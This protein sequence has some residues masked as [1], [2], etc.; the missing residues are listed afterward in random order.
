MTNNFVR[1]HARLRPRQA[2]AIGVATL[3]FVGVSGSGAPAAETS[4]AA[5]G[6]F[7]V[8]IVSSG[9]AINI[10]DPN[11]V[12]Q[13]DVSV[14]PYTALANLDNLGQSTAQAG[15]PFLGDYVGPLVGHYNGLAA[16]Q[17]PP[18]PPIP[19]EVRSSYPGQPSAAQR[20]GGYS[21]EATSAENESTGAVNLGSAAPGSQ[22]AQLYSLAHAV[23]GAKG[24]LQAVGSAGADLLN[25]AGVLNIGRVSS[26]ITMTQS[27]SGAPK[28]VTT[29]DV[30]TISVSGQKFG[31]DQNGLTFAGT[32]SGASAAQVNDATQALKDSGLSIRLIP[33]SV[34][35]APGTQTVESLRSG[36][37]EVSYAQEV[38]SQGLVTNTYTLGFVE[39]SSTSSSYGT[40]AASQFDNVSADRRASSGKGSATPRASQA[41][42]LTSAGHAL[43]FSTT[44]LGAASRAPAHKGEAAGE[45]KSVALITPTLR[46]LRF[47]ST[48]GLPDGCNIF[49]G[50]LGAGAGE[51]GGG[52]DAGTAL[53]SGVDGCTTLGNSGGEQLTGALTQV[54]PLVVINPLINPGIDAFADALESLGRDQ[55]QAVAPFGPTLVGM[56]NS[57]R[58]FK[59][60]EAC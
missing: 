20:N 43:S 24:A 53:S 27:G 1:P 47:G 36:A 40:V 34:A 41:P 21:I 56:A 49:F 3:L 31:L 26:L 38:P 55:E 51:L 19:G 14:G 52:S 42:S 44:S 25:I 16:G 45:E 30:G 8:R 13:P 22:N 48:L 9:V 7:N 4:P 17:A 28:F 5:A 50:A 2:S 23:V 33:A 37:V 12:L 39:V 11:L 58:F 10:H 59:G 32:S 15:A 46:T 57:A 29:T 35:Y 18:S 54:E 6:I 60:C